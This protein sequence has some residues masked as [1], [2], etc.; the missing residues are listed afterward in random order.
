LG[1]AWR[2]IKQDY[3]GVA[4]PTAEASRQTVETKPVSLRV[5]PRERFSVS[6]MNVFATTD[7]RPKFKD[8]VDLASEIHV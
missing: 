2:K 6:R 5:H 7:P 4:K 3:S 8:H 1:E